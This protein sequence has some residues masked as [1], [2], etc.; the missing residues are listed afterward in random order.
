MNTPMLDAFLEGAVPF[1]HE[2]E[3]MR[4]ELVALKA[5]LAACEKIVEAAKALDAD[6]SDFTDSWVEQHNL[7]AAMSNYRAA[8]AAETQGEKV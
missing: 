8:V 2:R 5:R 4:A 6:L 1:P 3:W 7:R